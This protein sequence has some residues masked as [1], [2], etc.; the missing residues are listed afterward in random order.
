MQVAAAVRASISR[1]NESIFYNQKLSPIKMALVPDGALPP[2]DDELIQKGGITPWQKRL[3]RLA[4]RPL[5]TLFEKQAGNGSLPL[6]LACPEKLPGRRFAI[7]NNFLALLKMQT[8]QAIDIDNSYLFPFGRAAG[9]YA[10][11]TAMLYVEKNPGSQVIVGGVDSYIDPYLLGTLAQDNR[12]AGA[13]VMDGFIPGEGAAFLLIGD[14]SLTGDVSLSTGDAS[15]STGD[16]SATATDKPRFVLHPPGIASEPGHRYS[17]EPYRGEGLANAVT[18]ALDVKLSSKID[19][20]MISFN[21][22]NF[23][24]K[25]WGVA[26]IRNASAFTAGPEL[27]HPADCFGDAGAAFGPIAIGISIMGIHKKYL[28]SPALICCSSEMEQRAAVCLTVI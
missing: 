20:I 22:E 15:L 27:L 18:S 26:A 3:L 19:T 16:A 7:S 1:F 4:T 5:T 2:L 25:E 23:F 14:A 11:E 28:T 6:F 12:I 17:S 21:G 9:L 10:L 8:K 13:G 24:A